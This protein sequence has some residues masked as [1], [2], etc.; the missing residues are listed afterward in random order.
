WEPP[1]PREK[2]EHIELGG[3]RDLTQ[4]FK[5]LLAAPNICSKRWITEQYETYV[6]LVGLQ[7]PGGDA[8]VVRVKGT[9]RALAMALDGNGRAS[10]GRNQLP[11][12][13]QPGETA[14]H[15][16]VFAGGGRHRPCLRGARYPHHRR[17]R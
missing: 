6:Q 17:Q 16:A 10:C 15:V 14:N 9:D 12:L 13:R 4:E 7:R 8:G 5:R 3:G 1:V 2:P 11:E